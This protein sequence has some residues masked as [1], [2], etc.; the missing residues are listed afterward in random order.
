MALA[1]AA[2]LVAG[3]DALDTMSNGLAHTQAVAASLEQSLGHRPLVAFRWSNGSLDTVTVTFDGVPSSRTLA[4]IAEQSR[5]A[6]RAH[7]SEDP[8]AIIVA[9]AL[10]P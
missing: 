5:A 9:F 2:V 10:E 4:E 1:I 8:D 3:C 7:F 6:V